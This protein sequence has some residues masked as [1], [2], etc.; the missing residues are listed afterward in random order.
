MIIAAHAILILAAVL[1]LFPAT[2]GF[3][4]DGSRYTPNYLRAVIYG[5][6]K[7]ALFLLVMLGIVAICTSFVMVVAHWTSL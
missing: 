5:A 2:G 4:S 1:L 3:W 7:W 6:Y